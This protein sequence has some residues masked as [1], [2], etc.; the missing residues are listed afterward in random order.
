MVHENSIGQYLSPRIWANAQLNSPLL[1]YH[2]VNLWRHCHT[3]NNISSLTIV[4]KLL[5]E[6]VNRLMLE[7][8]GSLTASV[9]DNLLSMDTLYILWIKTYDIACKL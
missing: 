4:S 3:I 6:S 9:T 2:N 8:C 1:W 5:V 7:I